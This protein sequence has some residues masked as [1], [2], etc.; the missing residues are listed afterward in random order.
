MK[1]TEPFSIDVFLSKIYFR[2]NSSRK[3]CLIFYKHNLSLKHSF[4]NIV[5]FL[6][7]VIIFPGDAGTCEKN[8]Y[9]NT[10]TFVNLRI[11]NNY[12]FFYLGGYG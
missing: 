6:Y 8:T 3:L 11:I 9:C 2:R 1:Y 10:D 5:K 4:R 12:I 7:A